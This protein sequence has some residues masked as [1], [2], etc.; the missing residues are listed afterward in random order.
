MQE[1]ISRSEA[2]R[3]G[4]NQYFTNVPCKN[5]HT[6]YRYTAS[7]SCSACIR[8][9]G[10]PVEQL[11]SRAALR[12]KLADLVSFRTR[13]ADIDLGFISQMVLASVQAREAG[14]SMR[15]VFKTGP[16]V[17]R[18][19]TSGIHSFNCFAEDLEQLRAAAVKIFDS[20]CVQVTDIPSY[21]PPAPEWP[22][23]DPR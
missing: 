18:V 2:I 14:A 10:A 20:R 22:E 21:V 1:V 17:K 16:G 4:L 19:E 3:R 12:A 7:G 11:Q 13:V 5:G 8:S 15:D 6:T 23:G 9:Y